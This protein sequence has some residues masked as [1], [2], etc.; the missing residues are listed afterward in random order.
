MPGHGESIMIE[1][2]P[3]SHETQAAT[4]TR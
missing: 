4:T 1:L 3:T 2:Y